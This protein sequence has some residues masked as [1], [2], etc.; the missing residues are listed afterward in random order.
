M[1][2]EHDEN[3]EADHT[4]QGEFCDIQNLGRAM[5]P[6]FLRRLV[7]LNEESMIHE[8]PTSVRPRASPIGGKPLYAKKTV[9]TNR[10]VLYLPPQQVSWLKGRRNLHEENEMPFVVQP[11]ALVD[12][13]WHSSMPTASREKNQAHTAAIVSTGP[14]AVYWILLGSGGRTLTRND[15]KPYNGETSREKSESASGSLASTS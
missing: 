2:P 3:G 4:G 6:G 15:R 9:E 14:T 7:A 12:P 10:Y 13:Y 11:H 5:V 8:P 1:P